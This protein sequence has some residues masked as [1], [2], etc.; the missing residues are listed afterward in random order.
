MI[1]KLIKVLLTVTYFSIIISLFIAYNHQA[2][3]YESSIY[4]STPLPVWILLIFSIVSSLSILTYS[5]LNKKNY[6]IYAAS[7]ALIISVT[8]I[9]S[10]YNIRGYYLWNAMGDAGTHYGWVKDIISTGHIG[11][12]YIYPVM[13]V[14]SAQ[15]SM[16][17]NVDPVYLYKWCPAMFGIIFFGFIFIAAR[18]LLPA[19]NHAIIAAIAGTTLVNGWYTTFL[20]YTIALLYFPVA[21]YIVG[22]CLNF[23]KLRWI[24][25]FVILAMLYTVFHPVAALIFLFLLLAFIVYNG[26]RTRNFKLPHGYIYTLFFIVIVITWFSTFNI[27]YSQIGLVKDIIDP[28]SSAPDTGNTSNLGN[29]LSVFNYA[30]STGFNVLQYLLLNYSPLFIYGFLTLLTIAYMFIYKVKNTNLKAIIFC[31]VLLVVITS[32]LFLLNLSFPPT[33]LFG[34]I[35]LLSNIVVGYIL[36]EFMALSKNKKFFNKLVPIIVLSLFVFL[37]ILGIFIVYPSPITY[38]VN[39]HTTYGEIQGVTWLFDNKNPMVSFT[40]WYFTPHFYAEFIYSVIDKNYYRPD[41]SPDMNVTE[42]PNRLGYNNYTHL[43][44]HY[45]ESKYLVITDRIKKIYS[46]IYPNMAEER[47]KPEDLIQLDTD[48]SVN[49]IYANKD[50]QVWFINV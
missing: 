32:V 45:N 23:N 14:L 29:M 41:L 1:E 22:K 12:K 35:L 46:E 9:L 4:I 36:F 43:S 44:S 21:V 30:S 40:S 7:I 33:R 28:V 38:S 31:Q 13:H 10:L 3:E 24:L 49:K 25:L 2:T 18:S 47:L 15:A 8:I 19:R 39:I 37:T 17:A 42:F 5:T 34:Y 16:L 11:P 27:F 26:T 48:S 20:P 50:L 6:H